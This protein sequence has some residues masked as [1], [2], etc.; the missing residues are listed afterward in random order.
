MDLVDV[1]VIY[2]KNNDSH[3]K[4]IFRDGYKNKY[5]I[6]VKSL[7]Q[8]RHLHYSNNIQLPAYLL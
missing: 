6:R 5:I 4:Y 1:K 2:C 8:L 3:L 7:E